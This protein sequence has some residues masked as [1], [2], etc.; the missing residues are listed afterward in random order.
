MDD[1]SADS[2]ETIRLLRQ[3]AQGDGAG[4]GELLGRH[5]E[6]LRRLV[7][8]RLDPR[9]SGRLDASDVLQDVCLEATNRLPEYL[10]D[11]AMPFFLWLRLPA[12]PKVSYRHRLHLGAEMRAAGREVSIHTNP[13]PEASSAALAAQLLGHDTHPSGAAL[14]AERKARLQEA[15]AEMDPI[16]REILALRHFEQL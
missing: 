2:E 13:I 4:L 12:G 11:P 6:R 3:A 1:M 5:R 9:V 8:L 7:A 15:L 10:H 14:R 16:D